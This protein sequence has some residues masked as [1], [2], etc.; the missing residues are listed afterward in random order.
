MK[1]YLIREKDYDICDH[2]FLTLD[3]QHAKTTLQELNQKWM[4]ENNPSI[5]VTAVDGRD[6]GPYHIEEIELDVL[7]EEE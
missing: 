3:P 7:Q 5:R 1:A 4:N 2:K 6:T